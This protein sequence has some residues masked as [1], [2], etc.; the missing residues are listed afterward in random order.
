MKLPF[1]VR[2]TH[3]WIGL[4]VGLQVL[5]WMVSG[6]YMTSVSLDVIHGDH[7]AHVAREPLNPADQRLDLDRL[8]ARYPALQSVQLKRLLQRDVYELRE[9]G[10]VRL[11][12]AHSGELLSPLSRE[13]VLKLALAAYQG[14]APVAEV[15]WIT[16]APQEVASR[17]VPMWAVRF[18][19]LA[20]TTLYFSPDTGALLARRHSLWRIFDFVWMLHIMDYDQRTDVNNLLLRAASVSGLLFALSGAGLVYF[21]FRRRVAR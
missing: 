6:V 21:S 8:R 16:Q 9:A 4:V 14:R 13:T 15:S 12:D 1:W 10:T 2:R 3:R 7:L 17:P 11:V 20:G 19:E 18:D 5:F